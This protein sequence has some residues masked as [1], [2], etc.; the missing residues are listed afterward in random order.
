[1]C[2]R[3]WCF[4]IYSIRWFPAGVTVVVINFLQLIHIAYTI[5]MLLSGKQTKRYNLCSYWAWW[6][7]DICWEPSN[8][9]IIQQMAPV[10]KINYSIFLN[11][12]SVCQWK[13]KGFIYKRSLQGRLTLTAALYRMNWHVCIS[14]RFIGIVNDNS[15]YRYV[16]QDGQFTIARSAFAHFTPSPHL[17][18]AW[19]TAHIEIAK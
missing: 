15:L 9:Q 5:R 2:R 1:M 4:N 6:E 19:N 14:A 8:N 18:H 16:V 11:H 3:L 17:S 10:P 7:S 13:G 12:M